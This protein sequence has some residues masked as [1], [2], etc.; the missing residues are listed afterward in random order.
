MGESYIR[1]R[2]ASLSRF[3]QTL[4]S[5]VSAEERGVVN[6]TAFLL[7]S[8]GFERAVLPSLLPR[9]VVDECSVR[10]LNYIQ[11]MQHFSQVPPTQISNSGKV[12]AVKLADRLARFFIE[13]PPESLVIKPFFP[14]CG[15]LND[16][17]G[18]VLS[19]NVL[20]EIKAGERH[21]RLSDIK[22]LLCYCALDFS[23]K[24]YGV[25]TIAILVNPRFGTFIREDLE[26]LCQRAAGSN[27]A[28]V[29]GEIVN[30]LSEPFSRYIA[31]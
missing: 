9:E 5:N 20:F 19:G 31:G 6:E 29:L 22:Q 18:D 12:D 4:V 25:E 10:A 24:V 2:N 30:F 16:A 26:T 17:E 1:T 28:D 27:T 8:R 3:E 7:F 15:W 21:F 13:M 23:G 11:K 14:G